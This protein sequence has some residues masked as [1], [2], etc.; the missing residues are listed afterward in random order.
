GLTGPCTEQILAAGIREVHCSMI[1]PSAWVDGG[2]KA[3]LEA[4]GIMVAVGEGAE[5]ARKLNRDY[6]HW[7]RTGR[8]LVTAKFA[9][10]LDGKIA[11]RTGSARWISGEAA[12]EMVGQMRARADGVLVGSGT[13][14]ADDPSLTARDAIGAILPRQPLR[15]VVDSRGRLP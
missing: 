11:T 10:T 13:V 6:L 3:A 7:V 12:R 8:P 1:D 5:A 2:G 14:L 4:K 9:M 15:V